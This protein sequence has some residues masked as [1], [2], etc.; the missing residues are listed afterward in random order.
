M[1]KIL[2][3]LSLVLTPIF[4]NADESSTN[5]K[6]Q[7]AYAEAETAGKCT[8]LYN[9]L[10]LLYNTQRV[11][12]KSKAAL[13]ESGIWQT[14]TKSALEASGLS[15]VKVILTKE[16]L[17]DTE[18]ERYMTLMKS[19]PKYVNEDINKNIEVCGN[20]AAIKE[21]YAVKAATQ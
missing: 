10:A 13:A 8:A 12:A 14:T 17:I 5:P 7:P 1:L 9:F 4:A 19:T 21:K 16:R 20:N 11:K 15:R 6:D 2:I 3:T 18:Y